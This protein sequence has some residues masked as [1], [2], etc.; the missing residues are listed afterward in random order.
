[1]GLKAH[2]PTAKAIESSNYMP[3]RLDLNLKLHIFFTIHTTSTILKLAGI[4][5]LTQFEALGS[6]HLLSAQDILSLFR[7]C[8]ETL[9]QGLSLSIIIIHIY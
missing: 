1:M 8:G 7:G 6:R 4:N 3:E 2:I 9:Q 5:F